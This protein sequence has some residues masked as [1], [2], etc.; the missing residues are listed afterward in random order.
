M[1]AAYRLTDPEDQQALAWDTKSDSSANGGQSRQPWRE[2]WPLTNLGALSEDQL[3]AK[4][5]L[6]WKRDKGQP[7]EKPW[8]TWVNI[9]E[10]EVDKPCD[11][12]DCKY[13][14]GAGCV[15]LYRFCN[16]CL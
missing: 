14:G 15:S 5:W 10:G 16:L 2:F 1:S 7:N 11:G 6:T 8:Y 12:R 4:P 9:F 13:C 3:K